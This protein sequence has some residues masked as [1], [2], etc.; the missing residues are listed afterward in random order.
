MD[1]DLNEFNPYKKKKN[2]SSKY[3]TNDKLIYKYILLYLEQIRD[4]KD[5]YAYYIIYVYTGIKRGR[6]RRMEYLY[7]SFYYLFTRPS[8]ERPFIY[9]YV[10]AHTRAQLYPFDPSPV[11]YSI[12]TQG[13]FSSLSLRPSREI[14]HNIIR[15]L[16]FCTD[17]VTA[18]IHNNIFITSP[19][20][21]SSVRGRKTRTREPFHN[22]HIII[23]YII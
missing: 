23:I 1:G 2:T 10:Y 4:K 7:T 15:L 22:V 12:R 6:Y 3:T 9:T 16:F 20:V 8:G 17:G 13:L 21:Q 11:V 14:Q 5:I 18:Y 19:D